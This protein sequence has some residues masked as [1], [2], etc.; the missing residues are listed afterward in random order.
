MERNNSTPARVYFIAMAAFWL[1]FGLVT[2]FYPALMDMFQ[3]ETG[4]SAVTEYSN[5]I[6]RH[7]G[8]D[9][10][11]ISVLLF[12][13]SRE[14]ASRNLLTAAA[15]V[16]L[17]VTMAIIY[18]LVTTPYWSIFFL[19]PGLSCLAFAVWGFVLAARTK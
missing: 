11:S 4:I 18:S 14:H 19:V 15:T 1:I 3:T 9:I 5:H 7:D 6:W 10:L 12:A 8:F 16:A 17:L 13:L 2:A